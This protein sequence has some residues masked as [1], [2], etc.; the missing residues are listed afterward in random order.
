MDTERWQQISGLYHAAIQCGGRERAAFLDQVCLGDAALRQELESLL[1]HESDDE[2][3]LSAVASPL[4]SFVGRT[5]GSYEV[6]SLLGAGGMGE[7]Y[8]ARDTRLN[9]DVAL[10]IL[11]SLF[12]LDPER[13]ARFRLEAQTLASLNHPNIAQIY[14]IEETG[15]VYA[16]VLE[17]VDGPTLADRITRGPLPLAEALAIARQLIDALQAA[18]ERGVAHRDLKPANITVRPDGTVKVLDFG[19][20]KALASGCV[21]LEEH[22]R[23]PSP[24]LTARGVILG[25]IA[26]MAPEQA[27]G[28][29]TDARVDVWAF[30]A[31]LYEMVT[32]RSPFAG[33]SPADTVGSV[34][35]K[36]PDWNRVPAGLQPVLRRCLEKDAAGR[37]QTMADVRVWLENSRTPDRQV[38]RRIGWW[39][40]AAAAG[41]LATAAV[42]I[43]HFSERRPPT[44]YPI[45]FQI[46]APPRQLIFSDYFAVS[47]DG[48]QVAF[49]TSDA[50]GRRSLW[51]HTLESG[52]SRLLP[53]V[54]DLSTSSIVWSADSRFIGFVGID[55]TLK[56]AA[57]AGGAA[58]PIYKLRG[59]WGG[60]AWNEDDVIVVGQREGGLIRVSS[61]GG[62]P[63]PLTELDPSRQEVGHGGPRFLPDGRHFI[64]SRGSSVRVN[65]GLYL[66]SVDAGPADQPS[67]PLLITDSRP[68]YAPSLGGR[69]GHLLVVRD[70]VLL[71][72]PFDEGRLVMAGDPIPIAEGVDAVQNGGVFIALVSASTNGVLAYRKREQAGGTPI[73]IDRSGQVSG[74]VIDE[75]LDAPAFP[76]L[77][78]DG[79]RIAL[80]VAGDL[81]VY[82]TDGRPAI[83]LTSGGN[84][85]MPLW[86]PDGRRILFA[87][88]NGGG[89][90][91][92]VPADRI[93]VPEI[94]SPAGNYRPYG[95]TPDGSLLAAELSLSAV[96]GGTV[97]DAGIVTFMPGSTAAVQ[98]VVETPAFEGDAGL[99][100]SPDG[101]WLAYTSTI[102]G[103][104]EIWVQPFAE[105]APP[106]RVSPRGGAEPRWAPGGGELYYLESNRMMAV[107][108]KKGPAFDFG[109]PKMLFESA[110]MAPGSSAYDVGPDGRFIVIDSAASVGRTPIDVVLNWPQLLTART[111]RE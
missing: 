62:P 40:A 79:Q 85:G 74:N 8:R 14:G 47:P 30:G 36:E 111:P 1:A 95:W 97:T 91:R 34:L 10:K 77:S 90:I 59:G 52:E 75:P 93:A 22:G 48:R 58:H 43:A 78:P 42:S 105:T 92:S 66:G 20:A 3:L 67:Q 73:W 19:L 32:G 51:I 83:R 109:P 63:S 26:Y 45:R 46:P 55:A 7:V 110:Y 87:D 81:W 80:I 60:A 61:S 18:H 25:T 4:P 72:Y 65:S 76:R 15:G 57:I 101:R 31:T 96:S 44:P 99:A 71:A 106:V 9:R 70:G 49:M 64:Y 53:H 17:L 12:A 104:N 11:P 102:T 13:L 23:L 33:E 50:A 29:K 84:L 37:P 68:A 82:R 28:L 16:L 5:V 89:R 38:P 88:R 69:L 2:R 24:A 94:A 108:V 100:L 86:A 27:R 39:A 41:A 21:D 98:P 6:R 54:A 56:K 103:R 35:H 107:P